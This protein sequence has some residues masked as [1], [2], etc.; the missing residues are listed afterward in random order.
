MYLYGTNGSLLNLQL[1]NWYFIY[2]R[3][4]PSIPLHVCVAICQKS[5][6]IYKVYRDVSHIAIYRAGDN[7]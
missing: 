2:L 1:L 5:I 4:S 6:A 7:N 3:D